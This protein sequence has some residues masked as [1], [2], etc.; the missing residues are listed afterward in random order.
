MLSLKYTFSILILLCLLNPPTKA[1]QSNTDPVISLSPDEGFQVNSQDGFMGFRLSSRLQQQVGFSRMLDHPSSTQ[2]EYTIR[3]ARLRLHSFFFD[4]KF[5]HF[6]QLQMDRG[7]FSISNVEFRWN[8]SKHLKVH[9]GQLWPA[10]PRQFRTSSQNFQL[11]DRS[12]VTR[13][14]S[15]GYDL[16]LLVQYTISPSAAT[17]IRLL[18]SITHGEGANRTTDPGGL[19]YAGR[20]EILPMGPFTENGDYKESDLSFE[21][22]PKFSLGASWYYNKDANRILGGNEYY[23]LWKDQKNDL[24]TISLDILFKYQGFSLLSEYMKRDL[25]LSSIPATTLHSRISGG[26]GWYLQAGQLISESLEPTLRIDWL[27]IEEGWASA[28]GSFLTRTTYAL[29]LNKF[30]LGHHMKIQSEIDL[31]DERMA[32]GGQRWS[33]QFLT[34]FTLSF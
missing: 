32:D 10:G 13:Y 5:S 30:F 9:F 2:T 11:V 27:K 23:L 12:P 33:L 31:M 16:G 25:Q 28:N 20:M 19:A 21:N 8:T 15:P 22:S 34:Q 14:F 29:G 26:K 3:R 1:R 4:H 18:G 7:E 6:V 24:H 17:D